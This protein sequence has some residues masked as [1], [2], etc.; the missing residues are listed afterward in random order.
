MVN[1]ATHGGSRTSAVGNRPESYCTQWQALVVI[2]IFS[3]RGHHPQRP[4][5]LIT[6]CSCRGPYWPMAYVL[7]ACQSTLWGALKHT[8]TR[9][10]I[11]LSYKMCSF[12]MDILVCISM[13]IYHSLPI[14]LSVDRWDTTLIPHGCWVSWIP[15]RGM[16]LF[17]I[18]RSSTQAM[19][20][21]DF[22]VFEALAYG[23]QISK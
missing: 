5:G 21:F 7:A 6:E 19:L 14:W 3:A 9:S 13:P 22:S 20:S 11:E 4:A 8:H 17:A 18:A 10:A 12:C 16:P 2:W 15:R 1:V 23:H